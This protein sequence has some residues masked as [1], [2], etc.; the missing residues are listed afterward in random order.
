[1]EKLT[2]LAYLNRRNK[3]EEAASHDALVDAIWQAADEGVRQ[4]DIVNATH[5]T[6]ERIRQIC[7]KDYRARTL[8]RRQEAEQ[9]APSGPFAEA[10]QAITGDGWLDDL[11]RASVSAAEAK[12]A[13]P[14]TPD[15]DRAEQQA[16]VDDVMTRHADGTPRR[17]TRS[18]PAV[19]HR[20]PTKGWCETCGEWKGGK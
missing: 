11:A 2:A 13:P 10:R 3:V 1:M 19:P 5:L 9:S 7:D 14:A 17:K 16:V 12:F 20:C 4:V 8:K 18:T 15:L 6:R